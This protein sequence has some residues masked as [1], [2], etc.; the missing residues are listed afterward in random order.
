M[1][2]LLNWLARY[3]GWVIGGVWLA[4][5]GSFL[6]VSYLRGNSPVEQVVH[7]L[8]SLQS[9]PYAL[10][11]LLLIYALRPLTL[12]PVSV[13]TVFAGFL[14][15]PVMGIIL[16]AVTATGTAMLTYLLARLMTHRRTA[17]PGNMERR[18]QENV[19]ESVLTFR[20]M[21]VPGDLLNYFAGALR[22][23]F[24]A[25][26]LATFIGGFPGV[27]MGVL[28]GA[29]ITGVFTFDGVSIRWEFLV[30]SALLLVAGL[31]T[32]RWLRQREKKRSGGES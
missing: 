20:L 1:S 12:I 23:D 7:I 10:L 11:W 25:F 5:F 13:L 15:G 17:P 8:Q 22:I 3:R 21:S 19:F 29:S 6:L 9:S 30:A 27:V 31:L 4:L 28:A 14:F 2:G 32:A 24:W 16:S 26:S 18:L